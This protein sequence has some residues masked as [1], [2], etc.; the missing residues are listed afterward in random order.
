MFVNY[1][2]SWG[3]LRWWCGLGCG[4]GGRSRCPPG[5]QPEKHPRRDIVDAIV[6]VVRT[7]GLSPHEISRR[8]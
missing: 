3:G 6:Y 8:S 2:V 4:R 5:G 7:A 1:D